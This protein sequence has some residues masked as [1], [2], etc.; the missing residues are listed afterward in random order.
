[1]EYKLAAPTEASLPLIP[2]ISFLKYSF[3][4]GATP[5]T[6]LVQEHTR[7][8]SE[9]SSDDEG[10]CDVETDPLN[11]STDL[12]TN[13][14]YGNRRVI[15]SMRDLLEPMQ[16]GGK[17]VCTD[18]KVY[19]VISLSRFLNLIQTYYSRN[20]V[21]PSSQFTLRRSPWKPSPRLPYF[22]C[23]NQSV[24]EVI[25]S[26]YEEHERNEQTMDESK[27][28]LTEEILSLN[29]QETVR[30]MPIQVYNDSY[31]SLSESNVLT[32]KSPSSLKVAESVYMD[33][34]FFDASSAMT[35]GATT[36]QCRYS[37]HLHTLSQPCDAADSKQ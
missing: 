20:N 37:L 27:Q 30:D 6:L 34:R 11:M 24:G 14:L 35:F 5:S 13:N 36:F 19:L 12:D 33:S 31:Y 2:V 9:F 23:S 10:Y 26:V 21:S 18:L 32:W 7:P 3:T 8:T 22:A 16:G 28:V 4:V 25:V 17:V 1:M 29:R 15:F